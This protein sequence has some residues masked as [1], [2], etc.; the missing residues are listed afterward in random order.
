MNKLKAWAIRLNRMLPGLIRQVRPLVIGTLGVTGPCAAL[1][2]G[3]SLLETA[4]A[5]FHWPSGS[6]ALLS[7]IAS[8][9][10]T[11]VAAGMI[12]YA[13][14]ARW[15]GRSASIVDAYHLARIRIK[16][17][18]ITGLAAGLIVMLF[19]WVATAAYSLIGILPALLG[20]IPVLGA[21]ISGAAAC[22]IWLIAL[23]MEYAAHI[24]LVTGMLALTADGV[25]GRPQAERVL[26]VV[27]GGGTELLLKL[28]LIFGGWI[29][30][31]G[32][33]ELA[34][35]TLPAGAAL[36]GGVFPAALTVLSM[37]AV[38]AVYLKER[39]R[40]DGMKFHG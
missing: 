2:L 39:D 35:W 11:P 31:Q 10:V 38:S 36:A 34:V 40:Q 19:D 12:T 24:V 8:F 26:A 5:V 15:E 30:L 9:G 13:A 27:R 28:L 3:M 20:W 29:V 16:Q 21:V 1:L 33:Y 6:A 4:C 17:I 22:V 25:S 23:L 32:L 18:V 37:V 14:G 7:L